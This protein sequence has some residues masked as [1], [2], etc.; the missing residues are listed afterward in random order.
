MRFADD[1]EPIRNPKELSLSLQAAA[2]CRLL[3]ACTPWLQVLLNVAAAQDV[4]TS[5]TT[6]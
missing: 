1:T 5:D 4:T 2:A 3:Q 6:T